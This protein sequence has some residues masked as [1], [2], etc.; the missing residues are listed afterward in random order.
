MLVRCC[1]SFEGRVYRYVELG[2][3]AMISAEELGVLWW[4]DPNDSVPAGKVPLAVM[5]AFSTA[6]NECK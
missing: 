1:F 3:R 2:S 5:L 6:R 4:G